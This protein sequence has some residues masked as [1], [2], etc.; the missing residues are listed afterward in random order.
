MKVEN[1]SKNF[2][3]N[4]KGLFVSGVNINNIIDKTG[5][6]FFI[7]DAET[8]KDRYQYLR[9]NL[10]SEVDIFYAMKANSNIA[11]IKQLVSLGAG[12]EVASHGELYACKKAGVDPK[13]IVF[14]G[15]SKTNEDLEIAIEMGIYA[16]NAESLGEIKRINSISSKKNVVMD[17]ELRI[18]PEFEIDGVA[19]SLGGGSKK[20]GMDSETIDDVIKEVKMLKNVKLQGIHIFAGTG[21][22]NSKGF[23][24]NLENCFK[25]AN[26]L[27]N[28]HFKV[29]SIDVG[30]GI[31]IPYGDNDEPFKIDGLKNEISS[32]I[33]Q[34]PFIRNNKTRIITE[35]G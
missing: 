19:V 8:I 26:D 27:N 15:P 11:I 3:L 25:L 20:F 16:L 18:N 1:I 23:L 29:E 6:P 12:V 34:Y 10:P 4:S 14:G 33:D 21:I 35:P 9:D 2:E 7:Y 32:L 17:V 24:S 13:N 22:K 30:G 31:G 5:T 28:K